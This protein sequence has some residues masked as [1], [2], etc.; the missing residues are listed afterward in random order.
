MTPIHTTTAA[1]PDL[2]AAAEVLQASGYCAA[3]AVVLAHLEATGRFPDA[4]GPQG[5]QTEQTPFP[6]LQ[7]P[8][9]GVY[10]VVDSAEWVRRVLA[11]GIRTVQLRIKD[12]QEPT[13]AVQMAE[14]IALARATPGAQLFI[15]DHWALALQMGAYGVHVG[16]EDLDSLDVHT[17]RQAGVRL[18]ISTHSYS[19]V[20]RA[21]ALRPSYI[22]C[23]PIFATQ[24]KD[25]PWIPQGLD[26]LRYWAGLLPLPVVGIAGIDVSNMA[27]V[28]AT[29]VAGA[30]V[31][32]AIT[33]SPHP[34]D[35]CK[36][37]VAQFAQGQRASAAA[38]PRRARPT[39]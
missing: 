14:A 17:L 19:E 37:L 13:L 7:N 20:S 33:R 2:V 21:L 3:D 18:G 32:T 23:G 24:S 4:V 34:E 35:A 28:A 10:A 22:A 9:L 1:N 38:M 6:V 11:A 5:V 26:N 16:Q 36:D 29:G 25:M 27:Q 30:A 8:A 12:P 39:L 31:I 15:N